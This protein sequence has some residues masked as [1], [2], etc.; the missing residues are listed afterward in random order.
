MSGETT[1]SFNLKER[2]FF[3]IAFFVLILLT[4]VMLR[5]FFTVLI[6]SVISVIILKPVYNFFLGRNWVRERKGLAASLTL[7][8]VFLMLVI[9]VV[10]IVVVTVNQLTGLFEQLAALDLEAIIQDIKHT[11]EGLPLVGGIQP[12]DANT[13]DSVRPLIRAVAQAVADFAVSLGAAIPGL[14]LQGIIFVIVVATLLPVYDDLVPKLEEIS[15]LGRELSELYTLKITAMINSLVRGVFLIAILQGAA[16]GFFYWLAGLPYVFLFALLSMLLAMIP[17]VGISWLV[18][19][20]A[21]ISFLTGNWVQALIL[22]GGFYGVVNWIDILLRPKLLAE[23]ASLNFALFMLALFGGL[24]WAGVM[25]LF[26][27]PI[28][29]LLLVTTIEIYAERYAHEDWSFVGETLN[30]LGNDRGAAEPEAEVGQDTGTTKLAED[31]GRVDS[32]GKEQ[33]ADA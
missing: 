7:L 17:M 16:M 33:A 11:L 30:R 6:V 27:G 10:I 21:I 13:A 23:E 25:G 9:P 14:L 20:L 12:F 26:Y 32:E 2:L 8:A 24:A 29:M 5:S 1:E 18:I 31:T 22:L 3:Y 4:L 15:P 19:A 28:L